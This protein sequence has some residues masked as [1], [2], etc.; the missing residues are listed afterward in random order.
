MRT[1][2]Q[3]VKNIESELS[4]FK[5]RI[6]DNDLLEIQKEIESIKEIVDN[7]IDRRTGNIIKDNN[8]KGNQK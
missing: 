6:R 8:L 3:K 5:R 1:L 7:E 2:T 4:I